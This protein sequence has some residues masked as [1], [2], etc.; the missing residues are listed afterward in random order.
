MLLVSVE[1]S[2]ATILSCCLEVG[3]VNW[4]VGGLMAVAG[5]IAAWFV[6]RD[7]P[8]FELVQGAVATIVLAL[9]I[10][11]FAFWPKIWRR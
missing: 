5:T 11:I 6:A 3:T 1:R 4:I 2:K 8:N 10:A 7:A 9:I